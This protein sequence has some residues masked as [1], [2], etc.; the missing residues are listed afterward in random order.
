MEMEMTKHLATAS[1]EKVTAT[2]LIFH[3]SFAIES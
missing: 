1:L 3:N 2:S